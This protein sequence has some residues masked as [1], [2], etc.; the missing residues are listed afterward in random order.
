LGVFST[1]IFN[2]ETAVLFRLA[3][4]LS[5]ALVTPVVYVSIRSTNIFIIAS[6]HMHIRLSNIVENKTFLTNTCIHVTI[7]VVFC[8]AVFYIVTSQQGSS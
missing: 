7:L 3:Q 5:E 6:L 8:K 1:Q 4:F 2:F